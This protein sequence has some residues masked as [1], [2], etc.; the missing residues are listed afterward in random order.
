MGPTLATGFVASMVHNVISISKK[1]WGEPRRLS[2]ANLLN[3]DVHLLTQNLYV[4]EIGFYGSIG[5]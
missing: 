2:K 5:K 3:I 4:T 1:G